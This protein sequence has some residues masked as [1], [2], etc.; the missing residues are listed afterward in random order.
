MRHADRHRNESSVDSV[1]AA[2]LTLRVGVRR[3]GGRVYWPGGDAADGGSA[4]IFVPMP[5][6]AG[7]SDPLCRLLSSA[8]AAVVLAIP[9]PRATDRDYELAALGWAVDHAAELDARP[10]RLMVAGEGAGAARAA[11]LA[12][13]AR[14]TG[15]PR[16]RRQILV[17]PT[18]T[19]TCPMPYLLT[20]VVPATV[21]SSD[22]RFDEGSTYA[23]RL[24]ASSIEVEVLHQSLAIA[25]GHD[26]LS[27]ALGGRNA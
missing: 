1:L 27:A 13:R 8:A 15:W 19:E 20:G 14:D 6:E 25:S 24:R 2:G 11:Q 21:V 16:L 12:I 22:T 23:T 5:T 18:F 10:E 4:L 7:E 9:S 26:A 3:L 17:Y